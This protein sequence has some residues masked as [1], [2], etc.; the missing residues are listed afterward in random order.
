MDQEH[1]FPERSEV[2]IIVSNT[3]ALPFMFTTVIRCLRGLVRKKS[4]LE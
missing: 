1:I 4:F 3:F 2:W